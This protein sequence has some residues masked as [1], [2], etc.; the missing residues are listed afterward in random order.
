MNLRPQAAQRRSH[1]PAIALR[2]GRGPTLAPG[3]SMMMIVPLLLVL[4]QETVD[5]DKVVATV[6]D[7]KI[8]AREIGWATTAEL[9]PPPAGTCGSNHPVSKLESLVWKDVSRRYL[10]T[11]GLKATPGEV[12]EVVDWTKQFEEKERKRRAKDLA[13]VEEKLRSPAIPEGDRLKLEK[14]RE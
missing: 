10:E 9:V 14:R 1:P 4:A 2:H 8:T 5:P 12:Q 3:F 13:E 11:K 7:R 6:L